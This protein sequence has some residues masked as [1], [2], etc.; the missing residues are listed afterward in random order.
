MALYALLKHMYNVHR[1]TCVMVFIIDPIRFQGSCKEGPNLSHLR[2]SSYHLWDGPR[3][4][5]NKW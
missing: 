1:G 4:L 5:N 3:S 2:I